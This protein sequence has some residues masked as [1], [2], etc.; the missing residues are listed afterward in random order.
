MENKN[1]LVSVIIPVY[2]GEKYLQETIETVFKQTYQPIEIIAVDDGS[3]DRSKQIIS[4]FPEIKYIF[5]K[6]QGVAVARNTGIAEAKGEYIALLD[7]DDLWT[8]NKLQIQVEYLN[9]HS[10][11]D[12]VL[13]HQQSFIQ[14]GCEKPKWLKEKYLE[15]ST[16]A[17]LVGALLARKSVFDRI[18]GFCEEYR[19]GNDSDWFA[20]SLD[21]DIKSTVLPEVILHKRIHDTNESHNTKDMQVELLTIIRAS[22]QRKRQLKKNQKK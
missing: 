14:A 5:Q 17:Y 8:N 16:P 22:I 7:Q 18:G 15:E 11:I 6:N 13:G 2:N 19:Y 9:E 4:Q 10:E 12:Y 1:K 20:K 21:F 3:T